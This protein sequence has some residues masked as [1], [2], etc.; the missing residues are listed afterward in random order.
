[1]FR[2]TG[3]L[4]LIALSGAQLHAAESVDFNR[5]IRPILSNHCFQCH[6]SDADTRE[7]DLRLDLR[8][9]AMAMEAFVPGDIRHSELV[10]RVEASDLDLRMPPDSANKP[11]SPKQIELL[12]QWITEGAA[13][14]DHWAFRPIVKPEVPAVPIAN[15][16]ND[17][18]GLNDLNDLNDTWV[19]N[20]IDA[21]VARKLHQK[22]LQPAVTADRAALIRR[23][24]QDLL[25]LL[26]TV[27]E[28]DD[29]ITS[30]SPTA[31]EDLVQRLLQS[32]HYGERWG[33]HWLDHARY[34]DSH[35]YT[36]DG[37]RVM[38][39]FRDWVIQAINNDMP[40][41]RFTI[42]QLAGDLLP[43]PTKPQLVATAFHRNT[44][45]NQEGGV[46]ADQFRHEALID[47]VNTT[48]AVWLG[49]TVG[50]AQCHTHKFD[51]LTHNE[52]YQ[53]YAFFNG[54][55]DANNTGHTV[56]VYETEMFDWTPEKEAQRNELNTLQKNLQQLESATGPSEHLA[57]DKWDW[58]SPQLT[59][60]ETASGAS[61][62][63]Q[64]D[65]SLL[66]SPDVAANEAYRITFD[67]PSV[68]ND[69]PVPITAIRLR[70]LTDAS[71]PQNGPGRAVNGNFVLTDVH[72]EADG[73]AVP[74][75]AAWADHSQPDYP[76]AATIDSNPQTG[77]AINI[78]KGSAKDAKMNAPHEAVFVLPAKSAVD[79]VKELTI[80]MRHDRSTN[81]QVGRFAVDISTSA[82]PTAVHDDYGQEIVS[83]KRR[84]AELQQQ[85]PHTAKPVAQMVMQDHAKIPETYRLDRGNFLTP[86]ITGGVLLPGVPAALQASGGR[87]FSN[88][89]DL[90]KWLV[91][92]Q[93][94]L[95]ARVTVN[96]VWAKYFGRG[97]VETEND[98]GFQGTLPTHP[99]LLDWLAADFMEHGWSL[100]H[101]HRTIVTS[102]TY[103][104]S[105]HVSDSQLSVDA[106]NYWLSRQSR[107]RV[108]AEIVRDQAL[109][110]SG[111]LTAKLGGP[112]VHPPQ[113]DG[114]Y[115]F[116]QNNKSWPTD[117]GPDR[118]RR[119]MYTMF[120]R[121][122]PYPLL[123]TF[124]SPDF[125]T[126][127]T[128]RVRSNTPLQSLTVA[129]DVVFMELAEGLARKTLTQP[130]LETDTD[131]CRYLFRMCLTRTPD[132]D[133]L[134]VLID[135]L[136]RELDRF[137]KS[138]PDAAAAVTLKTNDDLQP[139][140]VAPWTSVARALLN[141]DEFVTRN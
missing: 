78:G 89:L 140:Q 98:F 64:Q 2:A 115:A 124:D 125:S 118:Y 106:G 107:F 69:Q 35:G 85:F 10:A 129:N 60:S 130:G 126:V 123:T 100:K 131:R 92:D 132:D 57:A 63:L 52:Y 62:K 102:A 6:G 17:L 22:N 137:T 134:Q 127:C 30:S 44:M 1:M 12:K 111:L 120:Y 68:S 31:Y 113:P 74:F 41:D 40:F 101:L 54:A 91:T 116:T 47:R 135:F 65:G 39:P 96:R 38:W 86:D 49:L 136:H 73:Q 25:G 93:N 59:A 94:P 3:Y 50:C 13:Y 97:L 14:D 75:V 105:S 87:T 70:V 119:T 26:P 122:A 90:A 138:P 43:N 24:Y 67:A 5:D 46:K 117:T 82:S 141:T 109:A 56:S 108:E 11:L 19:R 88:R 114:I 95:T 28:A 61:L 34:A 99:E 32:P 4:I 29:F 104:Q 79:G 58:S 8:E 81:Y 80:V 77:W 9:S 7:A 23:L 36:I 128:I 33:R 42:E 21:F 103:R 27:S 48:G 112:G 20:P 72:L 37:A 51:P 76:I 83:L 139:L 18:N 121:S 133:E 15:D 16:A 55:T 84:I 53:L 71:L 66:A 110:A 45:I